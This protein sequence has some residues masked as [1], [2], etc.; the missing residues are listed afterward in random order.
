MSLDTSKLRARLEARGY[1]NSEAKAKQKKAGTKSPPD[2]LIKRQEEQRALFEAAEARRKA[3]LVKWVNEYPSFARYVSV[4]AREL[5]E[6]RLHEPGVVDL[7][8][9]HLITGLNLHTLPQD[10][11]FGALIET[12]KWIQAVHKR[13]TRSVD[14]TPYEHLFSH[15]FVDSLSEARNA[16]KL[17]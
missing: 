13:W 3:K 4:L 9:E 2:P 16:L 17:H 7:D 15:R 1:R 11:R 14:I 6:T 10:V 8:L 5:P 12:Q